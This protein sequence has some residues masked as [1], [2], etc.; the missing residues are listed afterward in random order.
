M[1]GHDINYI[2]LSGALSLI[3][4]RG[5]RPLPPVNL[6]G[7]FAAGGMLCALGVMIALFERERSGKGQVVDAA[8]VD[9]TANLCAFLYGFKASGLWPGERGTNILDSGAPFYDT[10]ETADGGYMAVGAIEPQFYRTLLEGL[11]LNPEEMPH[12]MDRDCWPETAQT[13]TTIFKGRSRNQWCEVFD[14]SDACVAPVL[15]LGEAPRHHHNLARATFFRGPQDAPAPAPAPRLSRTPG[16]GSPETPLA[17][18]SSAE[19]FAELGL[20]KEEMAKL[21]EAGIIG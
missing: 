12:Q 1:A 18:S 21:T 5:E 13:F 17:G 19:I 2:A 11:G 6:L 8:M 15:E 4:R 16:R 3:G 7:D 9:G 20:S 14:G 10:Y